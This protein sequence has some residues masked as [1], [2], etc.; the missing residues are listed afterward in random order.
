MTLCLAFAATAAAEVRTGSA[1]DGTEP[2]RLPPGQ[3]IVAV[4]ATYDS[5]TG[6][7]TAAVTTTGPPEPSANRLLRTDF[8][9]VDEAGECVEPELRIGSKYGEATA[10]WLLTTGGEGA[11][12]K[13]VA[14]NTTTF[15]ATAPVLVSQPIAC[16]NAYVVELDEEGEVVKPIEYL[17]P[18]LKLVGPPPPSPPSSPAPTP[19]P[20]PPPAPAPPP[21]ANLAFPSK[22]VTLHRNAWKKV[23]VKIT[24]T[25]D[26]AAGKVVL[27]IG[28]AKGV[29][30]K[31][32]SGKLKLKSIAAGKSKVASFKVKLSKKAKARS[33]LK[34]SLTAA[35]G[36]KASGLLTVEAWKKKK[37][38]KKGGKGKEASAS[39]A[40]RIFYAY[41]TETS[42]SATLIGYAFID[43]EWAYH[44]IPTEGLPSCTE[45]TGN[46]EKE[47]CVK[48]RFDSTTGSVQIG[49]LT[50]TISS[51][52]QLELDG[53]TY[54]GTSVPAAGT[55]LQVEQEFIGYSGLCGLITGCSTWHEHLMLNSNGEFV[56][57]KESLTTVGGSGPGQTFI[58]AGS[59]PPDQHGTYA[60]EKGARIKLS[61]ADGSVETKT[62]AIFLNKEGK[63]DPVYEGLL[64]GDDYFTFAHT[65]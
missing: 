3:D 5:V 62:I 11:A 36:V 60:I 63:P 23:K 52:G 6:T 12:T 2:E 24:N 61:F 49:S 45:I 58:A 37:A 34:L 7:A 41:K 19:A 55:R 29:A 30:I 35:K 26:A 47:G 59:F 53:E 16:M 57:S 22:T 8:Y 28:K 33:K 21:K 25:G 31:P 1:P 27:K 48:Y 38:P 51:G 10:S 40:E 4:S 39:L 15:T 20:T 44:G 43:G 56:L 32:K 17:V 54:F 9:A 46:A 13:S 65:E 14:G 18:P 42:H 50:G 64:I